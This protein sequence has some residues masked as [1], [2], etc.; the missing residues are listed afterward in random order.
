M[1]RLMRTVFVAVSIALLVTAASTAS[2]I[3]GGRITEMSGEIVFL[4]A[5]PRSVRLGALTSDDH[6]FIFPEKQGHRLS[7]RLPVDLKRAGDWLR[8]RPYGGGVSWS[9]L[10]PG[11]IARNTRVDSYY[12]HFD[13][14]SYEFNAYN[15]DNCVGEYDVTAR[16]RFNKPILGIVL[17][18][19]ESEHLAES[20]A[21]V[22]L[23]SVHYPRVQDYGVAEP[24]A[25]VLTGCLSD[26]F[27]ISRDRKTLW[28]TL[29][30]DRDN[31]NFRV[32]LRAQ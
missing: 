29:N 31:D 18:A 27:R 25:D 17:R 5:A 23:T 7:K 24:G 21:E 6:M 1:N 2:A 20:D 30:S 15:H 16:L 9:D 4:D 14:A 26:R 19:D 11:T 22:G 32:I 3:D 12:V 13:N 28:V 10:R 8:D